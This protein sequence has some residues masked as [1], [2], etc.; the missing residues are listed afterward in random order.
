MRPAARAVRLLALCANAALGALNLWL[1][2]RFALGGEPAPALA[3]AMLLGMGLVPA[4]VNLIALA[5]LGGR[6]HS[7]APSKARS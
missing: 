5:R 6:P 1:L 3:L 7:T 2:L 4:L